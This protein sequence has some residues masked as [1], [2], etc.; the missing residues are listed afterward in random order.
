VHGTGLIAEEARMS[1]AEE[2]SPE[3]LA[4]QAQHESGHAA[5]SWA[6]GI[7]FK[8][9]LLEGPGGLP[10]VEPVRGRVMVGQKWLIACCGNI[11]EQQ[12][13]GL[14]M[15]GS[16]IVK[17]IL[18]G[19]DD[20]FFEVDDAETGEVILRHVSRVPPAVNPRGD[21]YHMATTLPHSFPDPKRECIR[22]WRDS[23]GFAAECRP[24]IDALADALLAYTELNYDEAAQIAAMAM[25]GK[26][27]P[28]IPE[29]AQ[30]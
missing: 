13:R 3:T 22:I 29:W 6:L 8:R 30:R 18:G 10:C 15:R 16:Q 25:T 28:V 27:A 5:A 14:R 17:L 26:P 20:E 23:E 9:M 24:A 11:A 7:P 2:T 19:G 4:K 21:L 1:V 12:F